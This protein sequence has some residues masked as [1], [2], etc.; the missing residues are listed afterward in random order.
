MNAQTDV[1]NLD[2]LI[3]LLKMTTS[4][5]DAEA[6]LAMRKA[7]EQI[8]KVG[9]DWETLLRGKVTIIEDPFKN[10]ATPDY[11]SPH[12][13]PPKAPAPPTPKPPPRPQSRPFAN[14]FTC[15]SCGR[16]VSRGRTCICK[17][18]QNV[19]TCAGCGASVQSG[20]KCAACFPPRPAKA[21]VTRKRW[22]PGTVQLD[23]LI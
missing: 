20:T 18:N 12:R 17:Q 6:L 3:K 15:A 8:L 21:K 11:E 5:H 4:S 13:A 7:N 19:Y 16:T 2:L 22:K 10:I 23:D 1:V 14:T 9:G